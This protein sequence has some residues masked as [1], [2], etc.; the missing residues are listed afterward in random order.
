MKPIHTISAAMLIATAVL[1]GCAS[2]GLQQNPSPSP[3]PASSQS[4]SSYGAIESI[5]LTRPD[6]SSSGTGAVVGGVVGGLLGNQVGAGNGK[7]AATVAG[8]VGGAVVGNMMEQN[9]K[10]NARD[11]FQIGVRLDNGDRTTIV[12]DNINELRVGNRVRVADGRVY[13]Y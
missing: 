4:G 7:A 2:T 10:V 13:R 8:V 12:Q 9:S 5:Q 3:Y 6:N 1:G 11:S